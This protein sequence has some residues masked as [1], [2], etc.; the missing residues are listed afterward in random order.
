MPA[1]QYPSLADVTD[2]RTAPRVGTSAVYQ[3]S[4]NGRTLT[5]M[6]TGTQLAAIRHLDTYWFAWAAFYPGTSLSPPAAACAPRPR[7]R[8]NGLWGA[9]TGFQKQR[10]APSQRRTPPTSSHPEGPI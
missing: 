3:R 9:A 4:T 8:R 10:R 6:L 2:L 5:F 7:K 1:W